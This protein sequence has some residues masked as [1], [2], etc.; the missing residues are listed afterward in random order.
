MSST[1]KEKEICCEQRQS[2]AKRKELQVALS[3]PRP[4]WS[5]LW[6]AHEQ[7]TFLSL[8]IGKGFVQ[9]RSWCCFHVPLECENTSGFTSLER[10]K[11]FSICWVMPDAFCPG[12]WEMVSPTTCKLPCVFS[13]VQ[14]VGNFGKRPFVCIPVPISP[15][16]TQDWHRAQVQRGETLAACH[17][18]PWALHL[19]P[20]SQYP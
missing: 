12:C 13:P 3:A 6:A 2:D 14:R 18:S 4:G 9:R 17:G 20:L 11:D 1:G 8:L 10:K 16:N 7:P 15:Q 19:P 5:I